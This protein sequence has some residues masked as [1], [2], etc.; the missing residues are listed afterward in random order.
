MNKQKLKKQIINVGKDLLLAF[1]IVIAVMLILFAYCGIW[2]PMVVV[3]SGSM[4]HS[5]TRSYIGVIDTGDMVF[6]KHIDGASDIVTYVDGE[7][8]DYQT[9][10]AFGDVVVYRPNGD[11]SRVPIIHRLVV[12]LEVNESKVMPPV[13]GYDYLN[14]TFDIPSLGVYGS[15]DSVVLHDYGYDHEEITIR[16]EDILIYYQYANIQ[17]HSGYITMGDH[18]T[19]YYDQPLTGSYEPVKPEWI[20][21]K[22]IGE[23]PWFGLIKL[24]LTGG[25]SNPVPRNSWVNLTIVIVLL[26]SVPFIL[27]FVL[28][29]VKKKRKREKSHCGK[30]LTSEMHV[31]KTEGNVNVSNDDAANNGVSNSIE[32]NN[33]KNEKNNIT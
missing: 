4:M 33:N 1:V 19:P 16:L 25:L 23:L 20:V 32:G 11:Y 18:N 24:A 12:W 9:Y 21:G 10:G 7:A 5:N 3:E 8:A 22:A 31:K 26:I 15:L 27:D 14:Y 2:P 29:R 28:P 6:V 17:P 30:A 13:F